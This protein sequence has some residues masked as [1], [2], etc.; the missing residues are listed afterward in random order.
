MENNNDYHKIEKI[1]LIRSSIVNVKESM[2]DNINAIV[3]RGEKIDV[4]VDKTEDL[5]EN[6]KIFKNKSTELKRK[7]LYNKY[8]LQICI[9]LLLI[10]AAFVLL[11]VFCG[12][13][14]QNCK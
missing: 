8:K 12:F 10:I 7:T 14:F 4:L 5:E 13:K 11:F 6:S 9:C 1:N 3:D 2:I